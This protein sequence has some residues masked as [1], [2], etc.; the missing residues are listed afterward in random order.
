MASSLRRWLHVSFLNLLIVAF[1]GVILRYKIAFSLPFID[2]RNLHHG[3][4]H[5]AF[6]GW[7]TQ[8]LMVLMVYYLQCEQVES[9]FRKYR[10][11][12]YLNLL[13]AYGILISFSLQ[14][15]GIWSIGFIT[16][17]T[18]G[19]YIFT[20]LYWRDLNALKN[21][22]ISHLWFK[23]ALLFAVLSSF[24]TYAEAYLMANKIVHQ[25]WYLASEYYFLHFQYNG[26]FFFAGMG[27]LVSRLEKII[28]A[29]QQ[30]KIIFW[31]FCLAC[32]P[33]FFLS[34]L[35]M[36]I[37]K[38]IYWLVIGSAIA[39]FAGWALLVR[40][41]LKNK[42]TMKSHFTKKSRQV[43][44]L[45][46]IALTIKLLLQV[47]STHPALSQLAF[48]FRPIVIGY[49]HL[50]LLGVITIFI[51]GYIISMNLL[52]AGKYFMTGI[53]IFVSGIIIN[54]IFLM[55]Q[56]VAGMDYIIIPYINESLL[57]AATTM[58]SGTLVF[59]LAIRR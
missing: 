47:G 39:Q 18:V 10:W 11:W 15:Y 42:A 35:W 53:W 57:A 52:N 37:P 16:L 46:A 9:A 6:F 8:I 23:S 51:L 14:G 40:L 25:N 41:I 2:Q 36:P 54:E 44:L 27:L 24:G 49:L 12:L 59:N 20:L 21:R 13:S 3:H 48:G 19:S 29:T 58:F 32:V 28:A 1:L 33:A 43:F 22:K 38:L 56:G 17:S 5:F 30:L 31:L 26:W 45:S 7:I 50:V 4:S 55:L 34:A